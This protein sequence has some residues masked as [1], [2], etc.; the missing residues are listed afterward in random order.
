[1]FFTNINDQHGKIL[2]TAS[3]YCLKSFDEQKPYK[4]ILNIIIIGLLALHGS[5]PV[6]SDNQKLYC[7]FYM[8]IVY[9]I[10]R[11]CGFIYR[12]NG[13]WSIYINPSTKCYLK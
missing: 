1:M 5:W 4:I 13:E 12:G 2:L 11:I 7:Y 9:C 3:N 10:M 6:M 8:V